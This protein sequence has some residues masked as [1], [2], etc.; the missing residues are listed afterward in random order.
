MKVLV[1]PAVAKDKTLRQ[2]ISHKRNEA[3]ARCNEMKEK[4]G[5]GQRYIYPCWGKHGPHDICVLLEGVAFR[6]LYSLS[7][8]HDL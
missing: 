2:N 5:Q 3:L 7:L 4:L 8:L 1:D 6:C